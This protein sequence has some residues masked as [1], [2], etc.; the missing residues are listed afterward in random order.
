MAVQVTSSA[1][2]RV[3]VLALVGEHDI[4][5]APELRRA[6]A[7]LSSNVSLVVLDFDATD[8]VDS[9]VLG[10][11]VG[12]SRRAAAHGNRVIGVNAQGIVL[13]ALHITGVD[14]L[15]QMP[16]RV[17]GIDAELEELLRGQERGR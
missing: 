13:K 1:S 14:D 9:T 17:V 15:L 10:V 12:A 6:M 5:T 11:I 7:E 16:Q 2:G 8:F 3:V 4:A